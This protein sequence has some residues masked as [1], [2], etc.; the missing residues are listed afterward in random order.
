[1]NIVD[2]AAFLAEPGE[3]H[4]FLRDDL[5]IR[6][7]GMERFGR[8]DRYG[9][10]LAA[11]ERFADAAREFQRA[12]ELKPRL[13]AAHSEL[14]ATYFR[15]GKFVPAIEAAEAALALKA[16]DFGALQTLGLARAA[17]GRTTAAVDPLTK[18]LSLV[19]P[20]SAEAAAVRTT[21]T[22]LQ[23]K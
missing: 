8:F 5:L 21:L 1:M 9:R 19:A 6:P 3:P 14:A 10:A 16:N 7:D 15:Q 12:I 13:F 22:E 2:S 18:A 23:S 4:R 11:A 20:A 17:A